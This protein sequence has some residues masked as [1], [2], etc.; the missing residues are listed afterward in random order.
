[1]AS[2]DPSNES[3]PTRSHWW[4]FR[5]RSR[6]QTSY[7]QAPGHDGEPIEEDGTYVPD[8]VPEEWVDNQTAHRVNR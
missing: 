1:M 8:R 7:H 3:R 4:Q 2:A 5:S 6:E